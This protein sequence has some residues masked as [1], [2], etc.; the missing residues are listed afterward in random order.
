LNPLNGKVRVYA[1][2]GHYLP[3]LAM[4]LPATDTEDDLAEL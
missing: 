2:T 1:R 3:R 4:E